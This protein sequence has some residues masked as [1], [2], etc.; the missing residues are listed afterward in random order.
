MMEL[1]LNFPVPE[2]KDLLHE[3][4][5]GVA[6]N[7]VASTCAVN[8]RIAGLSHNAAPGREDAIASKKSRLYE[9]SLVNVCDSYCERESRLRGVSNELLTKDVLSKSSREKFMVRKI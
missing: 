4:N 5:A 8:G 3:E 7:E 9:A 6:M 2:V 1:M